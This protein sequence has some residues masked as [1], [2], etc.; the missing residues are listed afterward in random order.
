[1]KL[2][3]FL[4]HYGFLR[5]G[6]EKCGHKKLSLSCSVFVRSLFWSFLRQDM[7]RMRWGHSFFHLLISKKR[8]K[9]KETHFLYL[10]VKFIQDIFIS[11]NAFHC[12]Y[13]STYYN[14]HTES[15]ASVCD[16][17]MRNEFCEF[18][19]KN[20]TTRAFT[21]LFVNYIQMRMSFFLS[22]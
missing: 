7:I 15:G 20:F 8:K 19:F 21:L 11:L 14:C 18:M 16:R 5:Q 17:C 22:C 4:H 2:C 12:I 9:K 1:M 10:K 6:S 3:V 13:E